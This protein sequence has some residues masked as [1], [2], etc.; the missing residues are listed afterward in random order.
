MDW[1]SLFSGFLGSLVGAGITAVVAFKT[2]RWQVKNTIMLQVNWERN[3]II[4]QETARRR[5]AVQNLVGELQD[6]LEIAKNAHDFYSWALLSADMWTIARGEI[7]FLSTDSQNILRQ[8]YM[9]VQRYITKAEDR[10]AAKDFGIGSW[11]KTMKQEIDY[12]LNNIP[13]ALTQ[14]N[15]WLRRNDDSIQ[16]G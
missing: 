2:A 5:S 9:H 14:L 10:R 16:Q 3:R 13:S 4:E 15:T 8:V 1:N 7:W 11:D 12:L 6:N